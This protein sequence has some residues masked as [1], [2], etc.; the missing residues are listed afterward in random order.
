MS[1]RPAR[2]EVAVVRVEL[3]DRAPGEL[4][5]VLLEIGRQSRHDRVLGRT[6]SVS[7]ACRILEA[8]LRALSRS[9]GGSGGPAG[10][11]VPVTDP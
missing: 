11:D 4:L 5:I 3:L 8:W 2:Q 7:G 10:G 9:T 6:T 1:S